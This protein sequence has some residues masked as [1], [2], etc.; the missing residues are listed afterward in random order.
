MGTV[1]PGFCKLHGEDA[2]NAR[3]PVGGGAAEALVRFLV[4]SSWDTR[5]QQ[6]DLGRAARQSRAASTKLRC[7]P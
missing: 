4:L 2:T 6:D 5:V 3:A 1:H 7:F